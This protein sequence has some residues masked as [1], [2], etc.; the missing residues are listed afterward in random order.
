M[1]ITSPYTRATYRYTPLLALILT[2]NEYIHPA[3]GKILFSVADV[4]IPVVLRG[5][6]PQSHSHAWLA[7]LWL[8]NPMPANIA[9]RGSA[10]SILG[11]LVCATLLAATKQKWFVTAILLGVSVHFKIYP[12]IC[13]FSLLFAIDDD[14]HH[15]PLSEESNTAQSSSWIGWM[16]NAQRIHLFLCSATTFLILSGAMYLM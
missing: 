10:E 7:L 15:P 2:P 8:F 4:L 1:V 13:G 16:T 6:L 9:T 11:L 3:F 14:H 12:F 5:V